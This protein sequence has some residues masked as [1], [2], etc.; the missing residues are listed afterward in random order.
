MTLLENQ[1]TR[2]EKEFE[3][4]R[5]EMTEEVRGK[6]LAA[7]GK[8]RLLIA[9]KVEQFKGLCHKNIVRILLFILNS[10]LM[11]FYFIRV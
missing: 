1:V 2:I 3:E 6:I 8:T 7:T 11:L 10:V 4:H 5:E 9:Q